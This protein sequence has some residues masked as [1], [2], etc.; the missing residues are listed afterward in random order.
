MGAT[1]VGKSNPVLTVTELVA[2][3][4]PDQPII[5]GA[6]LEVCPGEV[7]AVIGA[8][9]AGKSTLLKAIAGLVHVTS[10]DIFVDGLSML[11]LQLH[12]RMRSGIGYVPQSSNVFSSLTVME[13]LRMGGFRQHDSTEAIARVLDLF[14]TLKNLRTTVAGSLSGGQRQT[15]AMARA[16]IP[17]PPLL[18]LDE[19]SAGLSPIAQADAFATIRDIAESGVGI[20][21]VEQNAR[22]CLSISHR[23][24]V[25]EQ[26]SVALSGTG[27][28]LLHDERVIELYLGAMRSTQHEKE[29]RD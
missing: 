2:G 4:D 5:S 12:Q 22:E 13:N 1:P 3:Y 20:L 10:G 18:L 25:L 21:L 15:L 19:P 7:V 27:R 9:G 14:P 23:G 16:I 17:G 26:G 29:A 11:P 8:N 24:L 6:H 28:E